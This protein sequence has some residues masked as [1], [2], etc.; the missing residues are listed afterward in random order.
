NMVDEDLI[1]AILKEG[2]AEECVHHLIDEANANGGR[3]N[4]AVVVAEI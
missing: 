4:I 3:D 1:F 2:S